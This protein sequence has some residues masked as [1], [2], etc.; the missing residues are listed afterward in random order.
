MTNN[1]SWIPFYK[2]LADNLENWENRQ[3]ELIEFIERSEKEINKS[4][5]IFISST[6]LKSCGC[7]SEVTFFALLAES[8]MLAPL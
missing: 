7:T 1:F 5:A 6:T 4:E 8:R 2:E 3:N